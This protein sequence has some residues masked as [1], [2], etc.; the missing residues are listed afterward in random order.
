MG[1]HS[2]SY[3]A[4]AG[5]NPTSS[6]DVL[7]FFISGNPGLIDYY[8]PFFESLRT[9]I[10]S[11]PDLGS[12]RFHIYGQDLAGFGE[13]DHK[14]FDGQNPPH[15][16]EYQIKNS[17]DA[18]SALR[19]EDGPK[20]SQPYDDILLMG[21]SVGSY[22]ALQIFHRHLQDASA[23]PHVHLKAGVLLFPTIE[24]IGRSRQGRQ[25][26]LLRRTPVIGP[27]AHAVAQGFL[28]LWTF[29]ALQWFVGKVLGFPPHAAAVTARFL[30]SR[31]GVW[32]ALH[33]GMDEMKVIGEDK[34]DEELWEIE[35][36]IDQQQQQKQLP[37]KF[38]FFF[39]KNDHWV[40]SH[41]RDAFIERRQKH[42][43]RT[44]L[45]IDEGNLPHAFCINHSEPVAEKVLLWVRE[46]YEQE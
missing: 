37:P 4:S 32:Q 2:L 9:L 17:Y 44:R 7:I 5:S 1:V 10:D 15:D 33:M 29:G 23:A 11:C 41:L 3:P 12:T 16:V 38:V 31:D 14:P 8:S 35:R 6:R 46:I 22:I 27:S 20:K 26:D 19:I 24:H 28:R 40:A 34:W 30:K 36:G 21:H 13:D 43:E 18:L 45:M 42:T 25:L 39:G